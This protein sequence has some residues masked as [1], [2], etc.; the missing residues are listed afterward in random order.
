MRRFASSATA[1]ALILA[2]SVQPAGAQAYNAELCEDARAQVAYLN[3]N[4]WIRR[5]E[6]P[7][8]ST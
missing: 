3:A 4:P 1:L 7:T 2:A 5:L 8:A 6:W